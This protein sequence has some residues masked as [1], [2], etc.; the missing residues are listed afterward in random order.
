MCI[1]DR[2][3]TIPYIY[4]YLFNQSG[5]YNLT[6]IAYG[7]TSNITTIATDIFTIQLDQLNVSVNPTPYTYNNTNYTNL[8]NSNLN[9]NYYCMRPN[10]TLIIYD[11]ITNQTLRFNLSCNYIETPENLFVN[12]TPYIQN[13]TLNYINGS[14]TYGTRSF[15]LNFE[16]LWDTVVVNLTIDLP[17]IYVY[18]TPLGMNYTVIE[19]DILP[20][21]TCNTSFYDNT[22]SYTHLTLPT[23]YSV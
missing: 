23:I 12:L 14:L 22:V 17:Q 7:Q 1:R 9:I 16:P 21:I 5:T 3:L 11:N 18:T 13:N 6:V 2:T 20:N 19:N 4:Q 15:N 8:Y 10:N